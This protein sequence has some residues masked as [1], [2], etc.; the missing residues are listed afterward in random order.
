M[1][2]WPRGWIALIVSAVCLFI[3]VVFIAT[4]LLD[5]F[6]PNYMRQHP[7]PLPACLL[8]PS[9]QISVPGD[10]ALPSLAPSDSGTWLYLRKL[11]PAG[12]AILF[13]HDIGVVSLDH[14]SFLKC[15]PDSSDRF[16]FTWVGSSLIFL[17]RDR[18]H[19]PDLRAIAVSHE[20]VHVAHD[21]GLPLAKHSWL[22][23]LFLPEEGE[24]HLQNLRL[25]HQLH[26][27]QLG[28]PLGQMIVQV[29]RF[30][31]GLVL[32]LLSVV[33]FR[34]QGRKAASPA[35]S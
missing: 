14:A 11:D 15:D 33:I 22:R 8:S 7:K 23:H 1:A 24:A 32:V 28:N 4:G 17:D 3:G 13:S 34:I 2:K 30:E 19:N 25:S 21:K 9:A 5:A 20:L 31:S 26:L 27:P 35:R 12:A 18:L 6:Q 16:A 29:F 10:P